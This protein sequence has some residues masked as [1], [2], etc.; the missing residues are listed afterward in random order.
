MKRT[1]TTLLALLC[2]GI[3]MS[4]QITVSPDAAIGPVKRMNAVNN[5]PRI[6]NSEQVYTGTTGYFKA[7]NVG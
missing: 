2:A 6:N 4:A 7:A 5:G 3:C 1:F